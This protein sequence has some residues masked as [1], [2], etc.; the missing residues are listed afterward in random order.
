MRSNGV[1]AADHKAGEVVLFQRRSAQ[2]RASEREFLPSAL[3]VI[4]TPASPAGHLMIGTI[5]LLVTVAVIW[6]CLGKVD[7]IAVANGRLIPAGEVKLIQPL[8]I[9]V[10]KRIAISEGDAVRRGD[11]L[12]ELDPTATAADVDRIARDL[13]QARLDAVRLSAQLAG[14]AGAFV[15]PTD[16]EPALVDAQKRQLL[17]EL[18]QHHAKL[19]GIDQQVLA[20]VAERDESRA[21]IAKIDATL[22][23]LEEKVR[24]YRELLEKS[25]TSKVN[26]LESERQQV[27]AK[28]TRIATEHHVE[29]TVAQIAALI[30]Q[31]KQTEEELRDQDIKELAKANQTAAQL[32]QD[33]I[34]A[35]QRSGL[36]TL[37]SPV[38]GTVEQLSVHTI[39]GVVTPAQTLMVVVPHGSKLEVEA[40]LPNRE[41]GF[42]EVGQ[43]AEI[44]VETFNYT[45]YGLLHGNVRLV[46]RD[47]LR[48]TRPSSET[49]DKDPFA[50]KQQAAG[51]PSERESS[52]M[53]RIAL[54]ETT[55]GT[56]QGEMQLG[57][58]MG[59]TAE[60]R[61][62]QRRVI[63]YV[64]SPIMRYRHESL[65][66]R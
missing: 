11:V 34:K 39:G 1:S 25:L 55:I 17:T 57:P 19:D 35:R 31:R 50:A 15:A 44:K 47:A 53:V 56:E 33:S 14:D 42:V 16:A 10:V 18:A 22:P 23:L 24:M 65:R 45:R 48:Y 36:Q 26:L 66:E 60:I 38:D 29:A 12:V 3:E 52:Y 37:R 8:E 32:S 54:K 46:G 2:R 43:Q 59:V 6:A 13:M 51:N 20:K 7:I 28:H 64:L 62:G 49:S 4:E 40:T 41:V 58:G 30:Q 5:V 61:T 21:T 27:E 63:E 9:G